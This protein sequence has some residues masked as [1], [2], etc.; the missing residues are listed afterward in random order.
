[1][2]CD[3][4]GSRLA[5]GGQTVQPLPRVALADGS[6]ARRSA[7]LLGGAKTRVDACVVRDDD[8]SFARRVVSGCAS[9]P[10]RPHPAIRRRA[11]RL[12]WHP[13]RF[14]MAHHEARLQ[15]FPVGSYGC[16][17]WIRVPS[18][19]VAEA[20]AGHRGPACG[21]GRGGACLPR[22]ASRLRYGRGRD[23]R[24]VRRNS[25]MVAIRIATTSSPR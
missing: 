21:S 2:G 25:R 24:I 4:A 18:A 14:T 1:M 12:L 7:A 9:R 20:S 5:N 23:P 15:L 17:D 10:Y 16:D 3:P 11:A 22:R 6:C 13:L 8:R 19:L